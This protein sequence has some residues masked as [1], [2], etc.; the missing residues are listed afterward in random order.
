MRSMKVYDVG[1][2]LVYEKA[3][4]IADIGKYVQ[5]FSDNYIKTP[6]N[7]SKYIK[8]L[9]GFIVD[10]ISREVSKYRPDINIDELMI[11]MQEDEIKKILDVHYLREW[12]YN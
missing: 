6:L 10:K 2:L 7:E 5:Q 11:I 9:K 12:L 1:E 3:I 8:D 4:I